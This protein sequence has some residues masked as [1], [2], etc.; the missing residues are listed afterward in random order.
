MYEDCEDWRL[1]FCETKRNEMKRITKRNETKRDYFCIKTILEIFNNPSASA[2]LN[3]SNSHDVITFQKVIKC[4]N[5]DD[6]NCTTKCS[7]VKLI[8]LLYWP[9]IRTVDRWKMAA[10]M[11][12]ET[13]R[14]NNFPRRKL[15]RK[16]E[17]IGFRPKQVF[18]T[19]CRR[20]RW[21][22]EITW[23]DRLLC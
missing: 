5:N 17:P 12:Q 8:I 4:E 1:I 14:G 3:V 2:V 23:P 21:L 6:R 9:W 19:T 22:A 10:S 20:A 13:T 16:R 15:V 11:L 18:I 7:G